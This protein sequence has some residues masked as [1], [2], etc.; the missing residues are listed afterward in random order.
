MRLTPIVRELIL[1]HLQEMSAED[2][3]SF[4]LESDLNL[5][6]LRSLGLD[7]NGYPFVGNNKNDLIDKA[8]SF[9]ECCHG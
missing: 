6:E 8:I 2:I 3:K 9:M 5:N 1:D 7:L 4:F